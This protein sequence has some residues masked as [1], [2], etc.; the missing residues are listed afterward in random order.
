[1]RKRSWTFLLSIVIIAAA[2]T[3][4]LALRGRERKA[5]IARGATPTYTY[6]IVNTYP[7]DRNA[8]TQGLALDAGVLYEGTG[9]RGHSTLRRV[10]VATGEILDSRR[11]D[12]RY[13]G[14]G[15]TVVDDRIVQL[16][17]T[18]RVGFI[19]DK[20]DLSVLGLP[21]PG[22]RPGP[23]VWKPPR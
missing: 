5:R 4:Y 6:R 12:D 1:M 11:L 10:E 23:P 16:T 21:H 2:V 9:R 22:I 20:Q 3:V 19:Y 14:E 8:F 18:S 13:F 15:I 7:H 17:F